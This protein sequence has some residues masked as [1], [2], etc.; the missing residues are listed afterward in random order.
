[1]IP[2]KRKGSYCSMSYSSY[3]CRSR[4][5][6]SAR[7]SDKS[8]GLDRRSRSGRAYYGIGVLAEGH[9]VVGILKRSDGPVYTAT[10]TLHY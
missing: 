2:R 3:S 9:S 5:T 7:S 10:D 8:Q 1:M 4:E 6:A